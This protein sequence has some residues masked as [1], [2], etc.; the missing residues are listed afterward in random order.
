M[1]KEIKKIG[2]QIIKGN[3]NEDLVRSNCLNTQSIGQYYVE[4]SKFESEEEIPGILEV[5]KK[6]L[7]DLTAGRFIQY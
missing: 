4:A 1:R 2:K 7:A 3:F 6:D 5:A